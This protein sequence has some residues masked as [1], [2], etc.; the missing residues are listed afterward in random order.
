MVR[1]MRDSGSQ[2]SFIT[3]RLADKL[4]L[5]VVEADYKLGINGFLS[6]KQIITRVVKIDLFENEPPVTCYLCSRHQN[7]IEITWSF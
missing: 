3:D 1:A 5:T 4:N 6:S 2:S 7:E